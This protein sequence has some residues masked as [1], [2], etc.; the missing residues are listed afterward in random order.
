MKVDT[1]DSI[2]AEDPAA[3][4][5]FNRKELRML[6]MLLRRLHFLEAQVKAN[7]GKTG[8]S[9]GANFAEWESDALEFVL[10]EIG[11]LA[12]VVRDTP[13]RKRAR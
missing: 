6:R 2:Y 3:K 1:T 8:L 9:G 12:E 11:Y 13:Q 10:T 7:E 4:A 5:E